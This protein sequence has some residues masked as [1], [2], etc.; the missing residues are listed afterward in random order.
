MWNA[1]FGLQEIVTLPATVQA[2]L[3]KL[4]PL[5]ELRLHSPLPPRADS[6]VSLLRCMRPAHN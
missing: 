3:Q 6:Q 2:A 5:V 1:T 4:E